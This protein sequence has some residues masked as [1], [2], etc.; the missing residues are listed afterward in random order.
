MRMH[1]TVASIG[2][3]IIMGIGMIIRFSDIGSRMSLEIGE[4]TLG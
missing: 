4:F 2:V 1:C 3:R